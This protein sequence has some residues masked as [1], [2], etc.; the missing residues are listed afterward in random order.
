MKTILVVDDL[1]TE[2]ELISSYLKSEGLVVQKSLEMPA[3]SGV[4]NKQVE[5]KGGE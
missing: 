3:V 2:L 4:S 5:L 1:Q